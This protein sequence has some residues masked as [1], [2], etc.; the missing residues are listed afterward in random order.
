MRPIGNSQRQSKILIMNKDHRI[1]LP[2]DIYLRRK[3]SFSF[4]MNT[5]SR[6]VYVRVCDFPYA[7]FAWKVTE[8]RH[9]AGN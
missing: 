5:S 2:L 9:T 1:F 3:A 6:N 8:D 4:S 7:D